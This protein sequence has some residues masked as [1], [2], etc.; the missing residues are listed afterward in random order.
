MPAGIPGEAH[1]TTQERSTVFMDLVTVNCTPGSSISVTFMAVRVCTVGC[2]HR[3]TLR[4][5]AIAINTM[6]WSCILCAKQ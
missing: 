5:R 3:M 6:S 4:P 2:P 1:V